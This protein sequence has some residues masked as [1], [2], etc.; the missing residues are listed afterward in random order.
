MQEL[1]YS[2]LAFSYICCLIVIC[3]VSFIFRTIK[4]TQILF[5]RYNIR[6]L[7]YDIFIPLRKYLTLISTKVYKHTDSTIHLLIHN[8]L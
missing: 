6:H 5:G 2:V 1:V 3:F 8:I 4:Q 7:A